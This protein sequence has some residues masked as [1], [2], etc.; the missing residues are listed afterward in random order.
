VRYSLARI[1]ADERRNAAIH[2]GGHVVIARHVGAWVLRAGHL[3][4]C[5]RHQG[6]NVLGRA[7]QGGPHVSR[8]HM[9]MIGVA[10]AISE[11]VWDGEEEFLRWDD[12]WTD[13]DPSQVIF[14][15]TTSPRGSRGH[16]CG[17]RHHSAVASLRITSLVALAG[18]KRRRGLSIGGGRQSRNHHVLCRFRTGFLN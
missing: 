16:C 10:G 17:G 7:S 9:A 12:A 6:R 4:Q 3:A 2:E 15:G 11:R 5:E 18:S 13:A 14:M 1:E 8:S